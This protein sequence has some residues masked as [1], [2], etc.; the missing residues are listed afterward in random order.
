VG[1][2]VTTKELTYSIATMVARPAVHSSNGA[3]AKV[4]K[5]GPPA[6]GTQ[7][8]VGAEGRENQGIGGK[9]DK[10][11]VVL[12]Q[13]GRSWVATRRG[14]AEMQKYFLKS[15]I[16]GGKESEVGSS[17]KKKTRMVNDEIHVVWKTKINHGY[18]KRLELPANR[19][20]NPKRFVLDLPTKLSTQKVHRL[21]VQP[22]LYPGGS[23]MGVW[24]PTQRANQAKKIGGIMHSL[25]RRRSVRVGISQ[26]GAI[27]QMEKR[28]KRV[29]GGGVLGVS[30][31]G[32]GSREFG[33]GMFQRFRIT[34]RPVRPKE[35]SHKPSFIKKTWGGE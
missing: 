34:R 1:G 6:S 23:Q 29:T 17:A 25:I 3:A 22:N 16:I 28:P 20:G 8:K 10:K 32:E 12:E 24:L 11:K 15:W 18:K 21:R 9:G 19:G 35:R 4:G 30:G 5:V 14:G 26:T 13:L 7:F 33:N 2:G 31:V 27:P